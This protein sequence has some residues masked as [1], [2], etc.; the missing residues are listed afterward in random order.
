[1]FFKR[2]D[3]KRWH[4]PG[5]IIG[6]DGKQVLVKNGGEL[7]RV[8]VSR[9]IHVHACEVPVKNSSRSVARNPNVARNTKEPLP[10]IVEEVINEIDAD[11]TLL[12]AEH[13]GI[14]NKI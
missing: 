11:P 7:I 2:Q 3:N 1:M 12:E 4:G 5:T 6:Q 10:T 14:N 13:H 9:L 8:H